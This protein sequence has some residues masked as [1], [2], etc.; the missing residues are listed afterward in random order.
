MKKKIPLKYFR[1]YFFIQSEI[2]NTIYL[3]DK[4]NVWC[5]KGMYKFYN[6]DEHSENIINIYD[7]LIFT[8]KTLFEHANHPD[9]LIQIFEDVKSLYNYKI[10]RKLDLRY[11]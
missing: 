2:E 3:F 10:K 8:K 9:L 5:E 6:N 1:D 4:E 11:K 7:Y